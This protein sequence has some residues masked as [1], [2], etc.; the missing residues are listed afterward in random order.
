MTSMIP[1]E[2]SPRR[3]RRSGPRTVTPLAPPTLEGTGAL[4]L[5]FD[6]ATLHATVRAALQEDGAF[7]DLTTIATVVSDRRARGTLVVRRDGV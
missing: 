7:H 2:P 4:K 6:Q 3:E 1:N 5:P